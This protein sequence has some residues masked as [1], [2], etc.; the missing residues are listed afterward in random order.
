MATLFTRITLDD[1]RSWSMA[2]IEIW[3]RIKFNY[4]GTN[5]VPPTCNFRLKL[6][7]WFRGTSSFVSVNI[8]ITYN[9]ILG[10]TYNV[11]CTIDRHGHVDNNFDSVNGQI[12]PIYG[13]PSCRLP[14]PGFNNYDGVGKYLFRLNVYQTEAYKVKYQLSQFP[15]AMQ[16]QAKVSFRV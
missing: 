13:L 12:V 6:A 5:R 8:F 3:V 14:P 16:Y 9:K 7:G 2:F 15:V 11:R 4:Q 1:L 10:I